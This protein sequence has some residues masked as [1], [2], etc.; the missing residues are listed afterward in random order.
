MHRF[1]VLLLVLAL[2]LPAA[3]SDARAAIEAAGKRFAGLA[4]Q[5]D[6]AGLAAMYTV[7][8]QALPPQAELVS[9]R[10]D[11]QKLWQGF[12]DAGFRDIRFTVLEVQQHGNF[13]YEVGRYELRDSTGNVAD[14][15]K[16][17]VVWKKQGKEWKL[18]RDIWNTSVVPKGAPTSR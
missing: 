15:G 18:H 7:D 12:L 9:G 1:I 16:Y 14:N 3:A 13:A 6:A 2:A 4:K 17:I 5:G 10:A 8:A 11:I